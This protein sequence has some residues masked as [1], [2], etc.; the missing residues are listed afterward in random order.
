MIKP[1]SLFRRDADD[2]KQ[3]M[4]VSLCANVSLCRFSDRCV[5]LRRMP[6]SGDTRRCI[7]KS[8]FPSKHKLTPL[9]RQGKGNYDNGVGWKKQQSLKSISEKKSTRV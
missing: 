7:N 1:S 3:K 4:R 9:G 2:K 8:L 5:P 6:S